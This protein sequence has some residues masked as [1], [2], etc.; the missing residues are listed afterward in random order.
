[1]RKSLI[2][3]GL[4]VL[5]TPF[6]AACDSPHYVENNGHEYYDANDSS[7]DYTPMVPYTKGG[8]YVDN[9]DDTTNTRDNRG[10]R[11]TGYGHDADDDYR[12]PPPGTVV[13]YPPPAAGTT[14]IYPPGTR[15]AA[16]PGG[17]AVVYPPYPAGSV[18][19]VDGS[20]TYPNGT[21]VYPSS[22]TTTTTTVI[23]H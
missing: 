19:N 14:V 11:P 2:G 23:Q 5:V 15:V 7:T 12:Q 18:L 16:T 3:M 13:Y 8:Q 1:M 4:A 21:V 10:D 17:G 9:P 6:V 20:I 22:T